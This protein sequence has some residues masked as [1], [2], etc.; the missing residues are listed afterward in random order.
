MWG[1]WGSRRARKLKINKNDKLYH[2]AMEKKGAQICHLIQSVSAGMTRSLNPSDVH[3]FEVESTY[4]LLIKFPFNGRNKQKKEAATKSI[5][6]AWYRSVR[7][8]IPRDLEIK[9]KLNK[10]I[11]KVSVG[12][13]GRSRS[14]L[15]ARSGVAL[16]LSL[17]L[18]RTDTHFCKQ[19]RRALWKLS[20]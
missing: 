4:K 1:G 6:R 2:Q 8:R 7:L 15:V 14:F 9:K 12:S 19:T 3:S 17:L 20:Y 10:K 11:K 16:P 18:K 5:I 13:P